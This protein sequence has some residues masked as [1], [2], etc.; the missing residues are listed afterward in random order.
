M[1]GH[2]I[3]E[4][5]QDNIITLFIFR[6]NGVGLLIWLIEINL[7]AFIDSYSVCLALHWTQQMMTEFW[8]M[9]ILL[10]DQVV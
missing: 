2:A 6:D 1:G 7:W 5:I 4:E 3:Q 10:Y 8:H 9:E